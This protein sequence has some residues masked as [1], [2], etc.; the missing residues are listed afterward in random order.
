MSGGTTPTATTVGSDLGASRTPDVVGVIG[1]G[2]MGVGIA[3]A[4]VLAGSTVTILERDAESADRAATALADAIAASIRRG[5]T[6]VSHDDLTA[7]SATTVQPA[8][9]AESALVIEAVPEDL[10]VKT[11]AL[12]RIEPH[13]HGDAWI[14]SNTSS[15]SIDRIADVLERPERLIGLHFFNPVPSSTLVEIVLGERT[16]PR[17]E[18]LAR[19]WVTAIG[20]TPIA[21]HD[22]PGFASSR[23]GVL[24]GLEAIRM[25]EAGVASAED[26]DTA[27][28]L[29]YK[30][31]V[32]PLR[33]TDLV[34]LDV[35]LAIAEYLHGTLGDRFEPPALLRENV[36]AGHL[37][38]KSGQG[39]FYWND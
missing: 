37:G 33:L 10:A 35:R 1:G 2:R 15:L 39:F 27:M 20:K 14:A 16:A 7:R 17:A 21:V 32:G 11:E 4:F 6:L 12:R 34:G 18:Q 3:H 36:A 5:T 8:D 25:L 19:G 9:L 30:H 13:L 28:V 24:L 29:G 31:P 22:S 26:I 38:R 23:L